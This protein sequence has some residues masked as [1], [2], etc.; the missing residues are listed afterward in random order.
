M[1]TPGGYPGAADVLTVETS[2]SSYRTSERSDQDLIEV[3]ELKATPFGGA[4]KAVAK[5]RIGEVIV[6]DVKFIE[7][8][9][10]PA[11]C[12]LPQAPTRW[13]AGGGGAGWR[14]IAAVRS[15]SVWR[16][17]RDRVLEAWRAQGEAP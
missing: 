8:P 10:A 9:G 1:Q 6:D 5:V 7:Q 16:E 2:E 3:L 13:K 17:L 4:L 12:G 15:Q 14:Q 11:F